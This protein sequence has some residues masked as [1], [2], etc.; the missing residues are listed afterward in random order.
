LARTRASVRGL[1]DNRTTNIVEA[2]VA[3]TCSLACF[4][5][6]ISSHLKRPCCVRW[7]FCS[8]SGGQSPVATAIAKRTLWRKSYETNGPT[9]GGTFRDSRATDKTVVGCFATMPFLATST[10]QGAIFS[11]LTHSDWHNASNRAQS[12]FLH[13]WRGIWKGALCGP[14]DRLGFSTV[15]A[16]RDRIFVKAA[17]RKPLASTERL[18]VG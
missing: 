15:A 12:H 16:N 2:R 4:Y 14:T 8:P 3:V 6:A 9:R 11:A 10:A 18:A 5:D 13:S 1:V 7:R 17:A